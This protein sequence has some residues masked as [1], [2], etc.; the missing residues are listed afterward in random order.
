MAIDHRD[1]SW[2]SVI[3]VPI[4]AALVVA[5]L[6]LP[7]RLAI[8]QGEPAAPAA[9]TFKPEEI[10]QLVAPIA[11]YP[12]SLLAQVLMAST[13]PLEVVEAARWSKANPKLKDQ[14]L[15][16]ALQEQTWDASVKSLTAFP[17]VLAMMD[18]KLDWT[19]NMGDAFLAQQKD[20][21]E[22][23]QRLR[24]KAQA[25]GNLKTTNEQKVTVQP[26][27]P[28]NVEQ[29]VNVQQP[30]GAPAAAAPTQTIIIE[31][32]DPQVVYVPQY[33]PS[34]YGAWPAPAYPPYSYYPP[35]YMAG[36]ALLS[37][38]VGMAVGGALWGDCDWG[39]GDVDIDVDR[40]NNFNKT[41]I[42][43]KNWNHNSE[44]RKGA[45]YRDKAS[46]QKYGR[47]NQQ[48]AKSRDQFRGRAE[49]GR[50]D[51]ARGGADGF[52][53]DRGRDAG[54]DQGRNQGRDAG[55]N[56][57]RDAGRDQGR[58]AGRNQGR[59]GGRDQ[60]RQNT[61]RDRQGSSGRDQHGGGRQPQP[62]KRDTASRSQQGRSSGAFGNAGQGSQARRE[63]DRGRSSRQSAS[64]SGFGGGRS[65]GSYGGGSRGGGG[66]S[67][68]SAVGRGGGGGGRGGGG[69]GRR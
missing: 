9:P 47:G 6:A 60:A 50:K 63:S 2:P 1:S 52:K 43:N 59:D 66:G 22:A 51:I 61:S 7:A 46:Q 53:G 16:D 67:R 41:D 17:Q 18:E 64:S 13:Y 69:R 27:A 65:S 38:G 29:N 40:Y 24:A 15:Q 57:G 4:V 58:D 10:D 20:V 36:T 14:A 44:H 32:A 5:A 68:G 33:S 45:Q 11:L 25:E 49:Q 62:P 34:V 12:D 30:A 28:V 3:K 48:A 56:Q 19:Q 8:A 42:S 37:F 31:P 21:M 35:G 26:A 55:R 54:R 39:G 23:V